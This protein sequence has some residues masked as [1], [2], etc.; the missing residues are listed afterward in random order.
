MR[1]SIEK[2]PGVN[3]AVAPSGAALFDVSADGVASEC[4]TAV[5]TLVNNKSRDSPF[6]DCAT[7]LAFGLSEPI[8]AAGNTGRADTLKVFTDSAAFKPVKYLMWMR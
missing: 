1:V 7:S 3:A 8:L 5:A 2:P 6:I 4:A